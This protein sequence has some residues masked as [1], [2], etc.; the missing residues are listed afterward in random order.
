MGRSICKTKETKLQLVDLL[1][2]CFW[3]SRVFDGVFWVVF[4]FVSK[5][6]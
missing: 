4:L 6:F 5:G 1:M 2:V 3:V